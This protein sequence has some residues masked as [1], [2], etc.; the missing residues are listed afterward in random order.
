MRCSEYVGMKY[1]L[2]VG[3]HELQTVWIQK[4]SLCLKRPILDTVQSREGSTFADGQEPPSLWDHSRL[5]PR[6]KTQH[7]LD[8]LEY[9]GLISLSKKESSNFNGA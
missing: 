8:L 6:C 2:L 5:R 1:S 7:R 9:F 3:P 4:V